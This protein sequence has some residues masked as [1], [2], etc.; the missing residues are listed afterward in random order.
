MRI[1]LLFP[2]LAL[3]TT[4]VLAAPKNIIYMIGDGMGPAYLTAYRYYQHQVIHGNEARQHPVAN[5]IFDDL[6]TGMASTYPDDDTLVTDSAAG[7]TAL[8]T[9][10]KSFNGAISVNRQHI[11]IGTIDRKSVV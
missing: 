3:S 11:P 6:L 7:A 8:A 10:V 9:G 2:L 1:L 4:A 5:T